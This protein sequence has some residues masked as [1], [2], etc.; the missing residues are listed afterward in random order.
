ML[1]QQWRRRLCSLFLR[2]VIHEKLK[3]RYVTLLGYRRW[4]EDKYHLTLSTLGVR[5][6]KTNP[7]FSEFAT[8]RRQTS[9]ARSGEEIHTF[10]KSPK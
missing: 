5:W 8:D 4:G 3:K 6:L 1:K 7:F 2:W 10:E 9:E